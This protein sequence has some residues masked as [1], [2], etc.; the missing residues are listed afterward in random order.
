MRAPAA[1]KGARAPT[2][3]SVRPA[4]LPSADVE[5]SGKTVVSPGTSGRG[6]RASSSPSQSRSRSSIRPSLSVTGMEAGAT[7][8]VTG[9]SAIGRGASTGF[10]CFPRLRA[11]KVTAPARA[12]ITAREGRRV[13]KAPAANANAIAAT[14]L[15]ELAGPGSDRSAV[16]IVFK[17]R[18]QEYEP[19][20]LGQLD[21]VAPLH[22]LGPPDKS[23]HCAFH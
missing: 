10:E 16:S 11:T 7:V 18:A 3:G 12:P 21:C 13:N 14:T 5:S 19:S 4:R 6:S 8:E 2:S 9:G 17:A 22:R 23:A 15:P 1:S 20:N